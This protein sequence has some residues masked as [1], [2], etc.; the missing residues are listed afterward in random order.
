MISR[1]HSDLAPW[2]IVCGGVHHLGGMDQANLALCEFLLNQGH[3]LHLVAHKIESSL[4]NDPRIKGTIVPRPFNSV[5][6][7]EQA[8]HAKGMQVAQAVTRKNPST[9]V[10]VNGGNCP[11]P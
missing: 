5:L 11:W 8:L 2:V 3:E 7:G 1:Q 9:R 6:L 10:I 4:L